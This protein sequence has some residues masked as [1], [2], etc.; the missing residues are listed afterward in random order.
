[1]RQ[2]PFDQPEVGGVV[3]DVQEGGPGPPGHSGEV[4][5]L[6]GRLVSGF[7]A[8]RYGQIHPERAPCAHFAFDSQ[9][10]RHGLHQGLGQGQP[11]P[12]ALDLGLLGVQA[13]ERREQAPDL[14][15]GDAAALVFDLDPEPTV[16]AFSADVDRSPVA[17]VLHRVGEQVQQDLGQAL[18]V[19]PD[20][21]IGVQ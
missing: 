8:G 4:C 21:S 18:P 12:G 9:A 16:G 1:M 2:D 3:L 20:V 19:R 11:Q 6:S 14:V 17:V 10:S 15:G 7:R 13:I 5:C